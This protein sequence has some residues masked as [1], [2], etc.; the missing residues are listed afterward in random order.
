MTEK[1]FEFIF[2]RAK[3]FFEVEIL[4]ELIKNFLE[5]EFAEIEKNKFR[6]AGIIFLVA[7]GIVFIAKDY[8][9]NGEENISTENAR[10]EDK[11]IS[12]EKIP[13]QKNNEIQK[14]SDQNITK[15]IGANADLIYLNNPFKMPEVA[16]IE[17]VEEEKIS[18]TEE[19]TAP[20]V[21]V[22]KP[23]PKKNSSPPTEEEKFILAGT[24]ISENK[25]TALFEH[26]SG[27]KFEGTL[28]L[29]VGDNLNGKFI[30]EIG[31][32]IV[33][34]SNGEKLYAD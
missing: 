30:T 1:F 2:W 17:E 4:N 32:D 24:A 10:I 26:Y 15:I 29:K 9:G 13:D 31:E 16:D 33:I 28:F 21:I 19:K 6:I 34:L 22:Q 11:N 27:K 7:F 23:E 3:K 14:V 12:A 8:F 20:V 25:K 5:R 18:E